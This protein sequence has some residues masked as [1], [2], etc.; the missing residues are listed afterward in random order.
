MQENYLAKWLNNELTKAELE[1]FKKSDE[2]ASYKKIAAATSKLQAPDFDIAKALKD[3]IANRPATKAV[4]VVRLNPVKKWMRIAAVI[5]VLVTGSY[6]YFNSLDEVVKTDLAQN[7]SLVLPDAST[8]VL[9]A[10]SKLA[11]HKNNWDDHRNVTLNGEAFFKVAK[12]KKFTVETTDG[13]V[14]VLGT[15]FN[16]ENRKGF[17]EVTCYE[18]L[19]SVTY[20]DETIKLP[21]GTSFMVVNNQIIATEAPSTS[22]PSWITNEST[23]KSIPLL[24]VIKEF[25][26]QYNTVVETK[27]IDTTILYTGTF[28]NK[29]IDLALKSICLPNQIKFKLEKNKV[30]LYAENAP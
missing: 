1:E 4:K 23:F 24:Y 27:N 22:A 6:F 9:N 25:E 20:K 3:S 10:D 8:V 12:G 11:Y 28:T 30:L 15:Q 17:F 16:V 7:K 26:R 13:L 14:T 29:N 18:G 21:G 5:L 2:Y 19:V